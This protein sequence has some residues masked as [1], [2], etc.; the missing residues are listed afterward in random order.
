MK[1]LISTFTF[2]PQSNGVANCA[3][4]QA[5]AFVKSGHDV[6]VVTSGENRE[7]FHEGIHIVRL[8]LSGNRRLL[9]SVAGKEN[10]EQ[11]LLNNSFDVIFFHCWQAWPVDG[12]IEVL[13]RLPAKK[14]LVSHGISTN[15]AFDFRSFIAK[16]RWQYYQKA[17]VPVIFKHLDHIVF[18]EDYTDGDRF[19]DRELK[20]KYFP[21][22]AASIIP[23]GGHIYQNGNVNSFRQ[24]HE[25]PKDDFMLLVVGNYSRLKNEQAALEI[26]R[27]L[28]R[29]DVSLVV[30]GAKR[31]DYKDELLKL[32]ENYPLG[33]QKKIYLLDSLTKEEIGDAYLNA[34]LLLNVSRTEAQPL[35]I[36]DAIANGVPFVSINRGSIS[37][38]PGGETCDNY[39]EMPTVIN[40]LINHKL[41]L[42]KL[43]VE[44]LAASLSKYNWTVYA[45]RYVNLVQQLENSSKD[46]KYEQ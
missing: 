31:N 28:N 22:L 37:K 14:V 3:Y 46:N 43:A 15:T 8:P 39:G 17:L 16:I 40:R 25:I 41:E 34:S 26:L 23:N 30:I 21:G 42:E 2:W 35:V 19:L 4:M 10:Y 5:L 24:Q 27:K 1:I 33:L 29:E 32:C 7:D 12:A 45:Q 6:T 20:D 36:L 44:G 38:I 11:F 18:L 9:D 13:H